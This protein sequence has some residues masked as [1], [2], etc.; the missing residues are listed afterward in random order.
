MVQIGHDHNIVKVPGFSADVAVE[1]AG[2]A[3]GLDDVRCWIQVQVLQ[4]TMKIELCT[5]R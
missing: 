2:K 5:K 4:F 1:G 3:M